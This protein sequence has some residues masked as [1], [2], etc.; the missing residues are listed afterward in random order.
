MGR[1]FI[2]PLLLVLLTWVLC[3]GASHGALLNTVLTVVKVIVVVVVIATGSMH[4]HAKN[5]TP[6]FPTGEGLAGTTRRRREVL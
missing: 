1:S 2:A 6:F 5:W 4:V 3:R